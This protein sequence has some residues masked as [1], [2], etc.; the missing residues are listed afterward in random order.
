LR[1]FEQKVEHAL[2]K[3]VHAFFMIR[4]VVRSLV[5]MA[6]NNLVMI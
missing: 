6:V 5:I 4:Q 3:A 1:F 2:A